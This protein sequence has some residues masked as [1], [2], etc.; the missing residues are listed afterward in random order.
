VHLEK[1]P[2]QAQTQKTMQMGRKPV[3]HRTHQS[4]GPQAIRKLQAHATKAYKP[5]TAHLALHVSSAAS[6]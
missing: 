1:Y 5:H 6:R 4:A 2:A 3:Q